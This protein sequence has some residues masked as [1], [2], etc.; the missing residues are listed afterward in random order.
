M[1]RSN[2]G[3]FRGE[4]IWTLVAVLSIASTPVLMDSVWMVALLPPALVLL[5]GVIAALYCLFR[6]QYR[7]AAIR[8]A[9]VACLLLLA[10]P[11]QIGV[12]RA[13]I[14]LLF[15]R[16]RDVFDA[17][18]AQE[19][20]RTPRDQAGPPRYYHV[21]AGPPVRI[22]FPLEGGI[23]DNWCGVVFDPSGEVLRL[24]QVDLDSLKTSESLARLRKLFGGDMV[25]CKHLDGPYYHCC[26]T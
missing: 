4:A 10:W 9:L 21:D 25:G 5:Y 19:L 11:L 1:T 8:V 23:V 16:D 13:R 7:R 20:G 26:F 22:A 12:A 18:V 14:H 17:I 15:D 6:R 3:Q 2:L 24:N